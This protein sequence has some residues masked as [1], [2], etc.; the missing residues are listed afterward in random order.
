MM[1]KWLALLL[2]LAMLLPAIVA[3][4]DTAD[5]PSTDDAPSFLTIIIMF[6]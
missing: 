5:T 6:H 2:I 3:C 4:G 1:K